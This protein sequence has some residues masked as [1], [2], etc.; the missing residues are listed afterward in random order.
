MMRLLGLPWPSFF[1]LIVIP[2]VVIAYQYYICW[3]I[4]KN[5]RQ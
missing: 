4:K 3:Q 2:L 1:V 5:R